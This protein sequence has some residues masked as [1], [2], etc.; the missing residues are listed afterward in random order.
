MPFVEYIDLEENDIIGI[1]E[2]TETVEELLYLLKPAKDI[3]QQYNQIHLEKRQKEFLINQL[4]L[5]ELMDK[6]ERIVKDEYGKPELK[7]GDY[8]ISISHAEQYS[9][10]LVSSQLECGIDIEKISRRITRIS[11]KFVSEYEQLYVSKIDSETYYTVIW[12]VKEAIYKWY[13]KRGIDFKQNMVIHPFTL[14]LSGGPVYYEF[15]LNGKKRTQ[16]AQYFIFNKH[17]ISWVRDQ[18]FI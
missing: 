6:D 5:Q 9:G 14:Q 12:C 11:H 16:I 13:A 8:K 2:N 7:F 15:L 1:W 17:V 18:A 10:L 4:L 3:I